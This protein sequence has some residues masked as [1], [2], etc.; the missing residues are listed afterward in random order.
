MY[1]SNVDL[2][3]HPNSDHHVP[4]RL[5]Y[6]L[7]VSANAHQPLSSYEAVPVLNQLRQHNQQHNY[8]QQQLQKHHRQLHGAPPPPPPQYYPP[9]VV[10]R[11]S[12]ENFANAFR[13]AG[14]TGGS[15]GGVGSGANA[16]GKPV[17]QDSDS[18]YSNN[19]SG[20]RGS[21]SSR[22]K[23]DTSQ[24]VSTHSEFPLS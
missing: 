14:V 10:V 21:N 5:P 3:V 11:S 16:A 7:P 13:Q 6:I 9:G 8:H 19:T 2:Q 24:R 23:S 17:S 12:Q 1:P 18:G 15:T 4:P 20:G 22:S